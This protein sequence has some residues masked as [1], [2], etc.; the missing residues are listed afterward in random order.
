MLLLLAVFKW[1]ISW[2]SV[3][4]VWTFTN[5]KMLWGSSSVAAS[6]NKFIPFQSCHWPVDCRFRSIQRSAHWCSIFHFK[7]HYRFIPV[8]FSTSNRRVMF[9]LETRDK[10]RQFHSITESNYIKEH[11]GICVAMDAVDGGHGRTHALLRCADNDG[12]DIIRLLRSRCGN[13]CC[14]ADAPP[15][16]WGKSEVEG[17][18]MFLCHFGCRFVHIHVLWLYICHKKGT[19]TFNNCI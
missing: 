8:H 13:S 16:I 3:V 6:L 12:D 15:V 4:D 10:P 14:A 2:E 18:R 7:T 1:R 11:A 9:T 19:A 5:L 17:W